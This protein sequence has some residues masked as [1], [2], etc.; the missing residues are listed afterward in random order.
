MLQTTLNYFESQKNCGV[1]S[2]SSFLDKYDFT[3][4]LLHSDLRPVDS[5]NPARP[6]QQQQQQQQPPTTPNNPQSM[7]QDLFVENY[8]RPSSRGP[9][10]DED[11]PEGIE[12]KI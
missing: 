12:V 7:M 2:Y 6:H 11:D 5:V 3:Q 8:R 9:Y 4:H 10:Q 1:L